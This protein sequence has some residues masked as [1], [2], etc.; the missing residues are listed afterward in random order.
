VSLTVDANLLVYAS[1]AESPFSD[2]AR[3]L[4]SQVAEG[5][6][7]VYLFWPV[8]MAYLRIAT[9]PRIFSDP[10]DP[11]AARENIADL[12]ERPHIRLVS[13]GARFW[14]LFR[15]VSDPVPVRGNLVSDAHLVALMR[16]HG[17]RTIWTR[18]RDFRKFDGIE[19][20]DP[21]E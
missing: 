19:A 7:L 2:R 6:D 8:V 17:V 9:H 20:I 13:E 14:G 12:V 15:E 21:F 18:D 3:G 16:E 11:R 1:D 4:L 5:P 10:L